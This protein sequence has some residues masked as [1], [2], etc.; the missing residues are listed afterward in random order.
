[1]VNFCLQ[2]LRCEPIGE[3]LISPL[4][5]ALDCNSYEHRAAT[6]IVWILLI[7]SAFTPL[8]ILVF[9][10]YNR[11]Q[12]TFVTQRSHLSHSSSHSSTFSTLIFQVLTEPF[13]SARWY[14]FP[15]LTARQFLLVGLDSLYWNDKTS[16]LIA[17]AFLH[18]F[19]GLLTALL[20]PYKLMAENYL[21]LLSRMSLMLLSAFL[22]SISPPMTSSQESLLEALLFPTAILLLLELAIARLNYSRITLLRET[23]KL[24]REV[25]LAETATIQM[26]K[27]IKQQNQQQNQQKEVELTNVKTEQQI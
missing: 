4:M 18:S 27:T 21:E 25:D 6:P 15:V 9:L 23:F 16:K 17:F 22:I 2:F 20:K 12:Q 26:E 11:S 8:L 24:D 10:L 3:R 7:F 13:S 14:W 19:V 5:P 1:M